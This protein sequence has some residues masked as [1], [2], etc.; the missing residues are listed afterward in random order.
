MRPFFKTWLTICLL[1][2]LAAH[3]TNREQRLPNVNG[4]TPK[5]HV[6]TVTAKNKSN[7]KHPTR[8]SKTD[9][10]LVANNAGR[11]STTV[12]SRAVNVLGTPY[13]WGGSS[14]SKGFDCSGLVRYAFND[15][16]AVDLPRTSNAMA[17]GHGQKVERKD[18]KPGDLLFF[19]IKSRKVNHVAI[20][21]GEDR[22]I[23]APRRGKAVTIDTL[24]K[25]Y[26]QSHYVVAKRVLPKEHAP[27]RVVQR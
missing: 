21:L 19:N 2:P 11:P 23:H 20:Y 17:S 25:P 10:K 9:S 14:P 18:L 22:F 24:K 16:A 12:L 26:W 8:L 4:Y 15:V 27:L 6:S 13:R 5:P 7:I 3:A 1:M